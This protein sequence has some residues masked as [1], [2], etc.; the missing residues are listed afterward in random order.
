MSGVP[1]SDGWR[2]GDE[3]QP[4]V[5]VYGVQENMSWP[6]PGIILVMMLVSPHPY[7]WPL[8]GATFTCSIVTKLIHLKDGGLGRSGAICSLGV[9]GALARQQLANI[10]RNI[11]HVVTFICGLTDTPYCINPLGIW[12]EL[13][14]YILL[15]NDKVMIHS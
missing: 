9:T 6:H 12:F 7:Y 2:D 3:F 14:T 5:P 1:L 8:T 15:Y 13:Y 11:T 10:Q 4:I